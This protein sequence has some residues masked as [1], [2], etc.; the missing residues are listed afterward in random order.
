[1]NPF[2]T[3]LALILLL[4]GLQP[5]LAQTSFNVHNT[6]VSVTP[7]GFLSVEG[8]VGLYDNGVFDNTDTIFFTHDW[9]NE[10]GNTG[11]S[12]IDTGIVQMIGL[13]QRIGGTDV[14][15]FNDLWLRTGGIKFGDLD[16][17]VTGVLD[18]AFLEMN[19]DTNT[20]FVES[21]DVNAVVNT[22]G[23]VS[24]L[25]NGGISRNTN[26]DDLYLFPVGSS[27]FDTIYRPVVIQPIKGNPHTY[28]VR[29]ADSDPTSEGLDRD[30]RALRI[31]RINDLYYH[32]IWRTM[33]MDSADIDVLFVEAEDGFYNDI[34][35]WRGQ[36]RWEQAPADTLVNGTPWDVIEMNDWGNYDTENF[37][38]A[39]TKDPFADAGEDTTIFLGDT[40]ALAASGGSFYEWS[41]FDPLSCSD[42]ATPDF[43]DD[44]TRTLFVTVEDQDGCVD[45]DSIKIAVDDRIADDGTFFVPN[46]ITPNGDGINDDWR[47]RWLFQFPDNEVAIVNRWGDEV[48]RAEPY[49]NDWRGT[50]NGSE[51]PGGTYYYILKYV[52]PSTGERETYN[53]PLTIVR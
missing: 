53:G 26:N 35:Q 13:D 27:I 28:K 10:A 43:F 42:C 29:F 49:Q 47:I 15:H 31:C 44:T 20:V 36:P 24:S 2:R 23:F 9:T 45:V 19:M 7:G 3:S 34:V 22:D 48:F 30:E 14:T 51:L 6:L 52:D 16:V 33:G 8:D 1:M 37:A 40:L 41:P 25:E 18:L 17:V 4:T 5:A 11:F 12:S 32:K 38:L 39:F 21:P 46:V 50:W